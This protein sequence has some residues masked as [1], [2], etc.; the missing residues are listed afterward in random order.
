MGG[1][2]H[3][4]L[5]ASFLLLLLLLSIQAGIP[6]PSP[7]SYPR[8]TASFLGADQDQGLMAAVEPFLR[9]NANHNNPGGGALEE[10]PLAQETDEVPHADPEQ[11]Q[12]AELRSTIRTKLIEQIRSEC[13]TR[14]LRRLS[15]HC[16]AVETCYS[17]IAES[18]MNNDLEV[19]EETDTETLQAVL[20][21]LQKKKNQFT[22]FINE[23]VT[24]IDVV[25]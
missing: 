24:E 14:R 19:S 22:P 23:K 11:E 4:T 1:P 21:E 10:P 3:Y 16:P 12:R 2:I 17:D 13:E 20:L 18:I 7:F 25:K 6:I 9:R 8:S 15:V 5:K